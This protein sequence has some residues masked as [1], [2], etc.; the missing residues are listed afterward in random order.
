MTLTYPVIVPAVGFG[1]CPVV[2]KSTCWSACARAIGRFPLDGFARIGA[3]I[4][5]DRAA[6]GYLTGQVGER[7]VA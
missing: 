5:A 1:S 4:F 2:R 6:A 7:E 3:V